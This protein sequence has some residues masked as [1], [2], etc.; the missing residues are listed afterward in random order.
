MT[1]KNKPSKAKVKPK[2]V[3]HFEPLDLD[4]LP[5]DTRQFDVHGFKRK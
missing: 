1:K 3:K 2:A 5:K 4:N